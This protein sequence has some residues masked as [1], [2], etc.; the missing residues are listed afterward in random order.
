[1]TDSTT[2]DLWKAFASKAGARHEAT[3]RDLLG[4]RLHVLTEADFG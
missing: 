1:M 4:E 3:V 2:T